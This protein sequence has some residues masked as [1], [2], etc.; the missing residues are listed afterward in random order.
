MAAHLVERADRRCDIR[1]RVALVGMPSTLQAGDLMAA[2]L[3]QDQV[4]D[5]TRDT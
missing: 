5:V 1:K 3:A 2:Q 4:S